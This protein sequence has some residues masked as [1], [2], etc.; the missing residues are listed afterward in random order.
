MS[1]WLARTQLLLGEEAIRTLARSRVAVFGVGGVGGYAVEALARSG[2]GAIDLVDDDAI[3]ETNI[4]R[5]VAATTSTIGEC[6]TEAMAARVVDINPACTVRVHRCF[7]LPATK[8]EL[9]VAEFDYVVDAMDTVTA[10]LLLMSEAKAAGVPV[11]SS[12]GTANKLDPTALAV[13]DIADTSVCPF[14]RIL[15]KECRKRGIEGVKVVYSTEEP[16][17]PVE[18]AAPEEG[19]LRPGRRDVPG[20]TAFVPPVA[21]FIMA[22]EVVKDLAGI[23][24]RP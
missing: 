2:V 7:Y 17:R 19:A 6:K 1:N 16:R 18:D 23:A 20:S 11:I 24:S 5:Q 8:D 14:A 22:S 3:G 15:R 21:G 9:D 10:K 12:M 13:A 4:N